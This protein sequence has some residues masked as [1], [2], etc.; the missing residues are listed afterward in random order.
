M[1][2]GRFRTGVG[3]GFA[4]GYYLGAK[5][6]RER[7]LQIR[8]MMGRL[9]D[10]LQ[11][12]TGRS[13]LA[14]LP[15]TQSHSADAAGDA[16]GTATRSAGAAVPLE[17]LPP[18]L[19]SRVMAATAHAQH[20][21]V[22]QRADEQGLGGGYEVYA[23]A[24]DRFVHMALALRPDG[25]VA[26]ETETVLRRQIV[27]IAIDDDEATVEVHEESGPRRISVPL[28]FVPALR[29]DGR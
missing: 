15:T 20:R 27:E 28:E 6:G 7:Y 17:E 21:W 29:E 2:M 8:R 24:G 16:P 3:V 13:P 22:E 9:Q 26:E 23:I 25:S 18:E 14:D 19:R 4:V 10:R 12:A 11:Q 5:A 1:S